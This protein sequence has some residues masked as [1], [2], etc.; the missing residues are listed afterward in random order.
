M[1][2]FRLKGSIERIIKKK[3]WWSQEEEKE[4]MDSNK[5]Q[6]REREQMNLKSLN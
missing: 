1:E 5:T 3:L 6:K 2:D 4:R